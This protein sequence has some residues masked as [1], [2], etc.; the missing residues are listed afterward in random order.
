MAENLRAVTLSDGSPISFGAVEKS[1]EPRYY[2]PDND[3]AN[4]EP[5]GCLY[6]WPAAMHACPKGWHL[7]S[8]AEWTRL[9]DFVNSRA[10]Y[11]CGGTEGANGKA[12][13]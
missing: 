10:D 6:N 4:R 1:D 5:Y 3:C 7:P 8:D 2:C 13:A 11:C 9:T 12:L